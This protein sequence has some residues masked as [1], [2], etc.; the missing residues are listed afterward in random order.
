MHHVLTITEIIRSIFGFL[1]VRSNARNA[2]VSKIWSSIAL[3]RVWEDVEPDVFRSL[4]PMSQSETNLTFVRPPLLSDW[5]TFLTYSSRVR[6]WSDSSWSSPYNLSQKARNDIA[7]SRPLTSVFPNLLRLCTGTQDLD[8]F[9]MGTSVKILDLVVRHIPLKNVAEV[10]TTW[11]F[12]NVTERLPHLTSLYLSYLDDDTPNYDEQI[13]GL[14]R[15]LTK[16]QKLSLPIMCL[17]ADIAFTLASHQDLRTVTFELGMPIVFYACS[18]ETRV[19]FDSTQP[20]PNAAFS[21]LHTVEF[22]ASN[23]ADAASFLFQPE[24]PLRNIRVMSIHIRHVP[25]SGDTGIFLSRLTTDCPTL[26]KLTLAFHALK[27]DGNDPLPTIPYF[28][29]QHLSIVSQLQNLTTLVIRHPHPIN[30]D[31][32]DVAKLAKSCPRL[33]TIHLNPYPVV[34]TRPGTTLL[35]LQHLAN[36]CPDL[37]SVGIYLDGTVAPAPIPTLPRR[38]R[39]TLILGHSPI[40]VDLETLDDNSRIARYLAD[41]LCKPC[42]WGWED[43]NFVAKVINREEWLSR[44]TIYHDLDGHKRSWK[45]VA[46]MLKMILEDRDKMQRSVLEALGGEL[47]A[48]KGKCAALDA[49]NVRLRASPNGAQ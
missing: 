28:E 38:I 49:E 37:R 4:C 29:L 17:N 34:P 8:P 43:T 11:V 6:T 24:F 9:L 30:M 5:M 13:V 23:L 40:S 35:A 42:Q 45:M 19:M 3:D 16:L 1:D 26:Q 32:N 47:S 48:W 15:N 7:M 10:R 18:Q 39:G 21:A 12:R 27:Y 20:L 22:S 31:D 36:H 25:L 46:V 2:R 44:M 33:Q 14:L 41:V